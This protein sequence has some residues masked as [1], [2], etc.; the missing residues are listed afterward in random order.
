MESEPS[1]YALC[2]RLLS[3][4]VTCVTELDTK[5]WY[6][7]HEKEDAM[8]I[9]DTVVVREKNYYSSSRLPYS[10]TSITEKTKR[11]I[12]TQ[13]GRK[14]TKGGVL[15]GFSDTPWTAAR[16]EFNVTPEEAEKRNKEF[17]EANKKAKKW[18]AIQNV[19]RRLAWASVT[20]EQLELFERALE[21]RLQNDS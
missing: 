11:T 7:K 5:I 10:I 12:T 21:D 18:H 16:L 8:N 1:W 19:V 4:K 6:N 3:S 2:L 13:D 17:D 20:D 9:N 14:W 15:W